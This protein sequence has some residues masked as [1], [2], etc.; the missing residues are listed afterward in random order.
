MSPAFRRRNEEHSRTSENASYVMALLDLKQAILI[1]R[2]VSSALELQRVVFRT[3][4][5][6]SRSGNYI[7]GTVFV[8]FLPRLYANC[9]K[10]LT[11]FQRLTSN[12]LGIAEEEVEMDIHP[13]HN[14]C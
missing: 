1:N 2:T 11:L 9:G 8:L 3:D 5:F 12:T 7:G 4:R 13:S 6:L 10:T 14:I